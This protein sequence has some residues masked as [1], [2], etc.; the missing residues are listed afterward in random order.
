M[1]KNKTKA[2]Q[3]SV[4][5]YLSAIADEARRKDCE[6]LAKPMAKATKQEPMMWGTGIVG[7]GSFT[8]GTRVVA[9]AV[10]D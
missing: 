8:T 4:E 3:A 6:A 2:T 7:F 5:D 1:A 9:K 10:P